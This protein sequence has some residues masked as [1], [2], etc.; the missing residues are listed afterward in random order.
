MISQATKFAKKEN[1]DVYILPGASCVG[2][3]FQ[4][5]KYSGIVGV[6]CT[7]ELKVASECLKEFKIPAQG[8]ILTKN[9]CCETL[10][11]FELFKKI[12]KA[13]D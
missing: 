9:G 5:V 6:A 13:T 10:F 1:Y 12:L 3:I 2:K 7:E 4:K 11:N 8:I